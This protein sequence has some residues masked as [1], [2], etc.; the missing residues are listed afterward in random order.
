MPGGESVT[1]T[2]PS[3]KAVENDAA[4]AGCRLLEQS[5]LLQRQVSAK[6]KS[7]DRRAPAHLQLPSQGGRFRAA[8]T[9]IAVRAAISE[10]NFR[11]C[12]MTGLRRH[13]GNFLM[14]IHIFLFGA[15]KILRTLIYSISGFEQYARVMTGLRRHMRDFLN[16]FGAGF[17][18]SL[19]KPFRIFSR[20]DEFSVVPAMCRSQNYY[21]FY[22]LDEM[23][24]NSVL[25]GFDRW[26]ADARFFIEVALRQPAQ[27]S[28]SSIE[29]AETTSVEI[30]SPTHSLSLSPLPSGTQ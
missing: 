15:A 19:Q 14:F 7:K 23:R 13:V 30:Y 17:R 8:G 6:Q 28:S 21:G 27:L 3:A 9:I 18:A 5:G 11:I 29:G 26:P 1:G 20:W 24:S 25:A 4:L 22:Y 12:V 10:L 2:G 16:F